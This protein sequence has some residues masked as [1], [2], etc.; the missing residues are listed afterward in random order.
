MIPEFLPGNP[1]S[2]VQTVFFHVCRARC[3]L[4]NLEQDRAS[5]STKVKCWKQF[6]F[7]LYAN[8]LL[9]HLSLVKTILIRTKHEK[10]K[11]AKLETKITFLKGKKRF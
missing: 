1:R 7:S 11:N 10:K 3:C 9:P 5:D 6:L 8:Q 4:N 2:S